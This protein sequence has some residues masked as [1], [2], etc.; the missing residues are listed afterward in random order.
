MAKRSTSSPLDRLQHW[1][2]THCNG[3]WE[4][5]RGIQIETLDNPGWLVK[6]NLAGTPLQD[7]PFSRIL[8]NT[9]EAGWPQSGRWLHCQV[10]ENLWQGAGDESRL[11]EILEL[12]LTWAEVE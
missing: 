7:K 10:I 3:D 11:A 2:Q 4:H 6:I 12:F 1:Y 9:D 8:N 5:G